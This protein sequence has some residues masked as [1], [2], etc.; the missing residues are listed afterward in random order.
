MGQHSVQGLMREYTMA[1]LTDDQ[2][3]SRSS[4]VAMAPKEECG[5]EVMLVGR[6]QEEMSGVQG[7]GDTF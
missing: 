2:C 1:M 6:W 5:A 4:N 7:R 3:W